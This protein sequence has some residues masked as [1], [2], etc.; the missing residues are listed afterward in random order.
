M[1]PSTHINIEDLLFY[2][3]FLLSVLATKGI[4]VTWSTAAE[5]NILMVS[6]FRPLIVIWI[7]NHRQQQ[8]LT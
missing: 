8:K 3:T 2:F 6:L 7:M 1:T 4:W 5:Y